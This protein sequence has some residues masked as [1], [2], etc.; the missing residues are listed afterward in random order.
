MLFI[1]KYQIC[2]RGE[3]ESVVARGKGFSRIFEVLTCVALLWCKEP[4]WAS[5][6]KVNHSP[7]LAPFLPSPFVSRTGP[8][9][10]LLWTLC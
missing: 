5:L 2:Y 10:G 4:K 1:I 8:N 7:A 9:L 6:S 3:G